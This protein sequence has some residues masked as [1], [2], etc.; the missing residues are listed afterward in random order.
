MSKDKIYNIL[1]K[2]KK[3]YS[4]INTDSDRTKTTFKQDDRLKVLFL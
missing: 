3:N 1:L 2:K 4:P